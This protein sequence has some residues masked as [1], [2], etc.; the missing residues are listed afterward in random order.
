MNGNYEQIVGGWM[1]EAV[2][3]LNNSPATTY[4]NTD[5][6]S[7]DIWTMIDD[8]FNSEWEVGA[9][10]QYDEGGDQVKSPYG[11]AFSHAYVVLGTDQLKDSNGNVDYNLLRIRNPW[12]SETYSGPWSDADPRWTDSYKEQVDYLDRDDG[13]FFCDMDTFKDGFESFTLIYSANEQTQSWYYDT[14]VP[15]NSYSSYTFTLT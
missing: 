13:V 14:N 9:E 4:K 10:T 15:A 7:Q 12:R 6:S 3:F 11:L 8:A 2:N 1:K 5:Y